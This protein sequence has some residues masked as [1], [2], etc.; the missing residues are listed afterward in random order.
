MFYVV[1]IDPCRLLSSR[2]SWHQTH[3]LYLTETAGGVELSPK[4]PD[5]AAT[6]AV[7]RDAIRRYDGALR[8]LAE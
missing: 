4:A 7:A 5:L 6:M 8:K 3:T 2:A 1:W